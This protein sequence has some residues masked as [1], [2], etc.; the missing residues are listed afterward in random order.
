MVSCRIILYY[1]NLKKNRI[2]NFTQTFTM[3]YGHVDSDLQDQFLN[4]IKKYTASVL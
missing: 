2:D 1:F 3:V 4:I